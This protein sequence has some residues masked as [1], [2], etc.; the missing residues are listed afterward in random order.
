MLEVRE[1]TKAFS[2]REVVSGVGFTV[3]AGQVLGYLGPNGAGKSTTVKMLTGLLEPTSGTVLF[4]GKDI[5]RNLIEYKSRLGYVP[6]SHDLYG[7]LSGYEYLRLVGQLRRLPATLLETKIN[8]LLRL[9][10]LHPQRHSVIASYSKGMRQ[11]ILIASAILHNPDLLIF[12]EPLSGLDVTSALV[13]KN[14]VGELAAQGKMILYSSHVLEVV[15]KL[16]ARV[17][18][19][20]QGKVVADDSVHNLRELMKLPSLERIFTELVLQEDI[21]EK[22][23]QLVEVMKLSA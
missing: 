15:E 19:L 21:Q 16:C 8:E 7:Y 2:I 17:V 9:F 10:S 20:D 6:E 14:L 22:A 3:Q 11:K 4:D 23:R 5:R 13:F 18:I 1:L 12:D